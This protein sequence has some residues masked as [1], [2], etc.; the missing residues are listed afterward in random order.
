MRTPKIKDTDLV[1]MLPNAPYIASLMP[2]HVKGQKQTGA[3]SGFTKNKYGTLYNYFDYRCIT[4]LLGKTM[5]K[6]AM[7]TKMTG[8]VADAPTYGIR[9]GS[10]AD[11]SAERA[12]A[13]LIKEGLIVVV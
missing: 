10:S 7:R 11:I 8:F 9:G 2:N 13:C 5:T 3:T 4:E 1:M 12:L 6:G